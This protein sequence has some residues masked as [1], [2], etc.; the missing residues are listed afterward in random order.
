MTYPEDML[1]HLEV[2]KCLPEPWVAARP[3]SFSL[4]P[5]FATF[6]TDWGYVLME[7]GPLQFVYQ[8]VQYKYM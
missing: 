8:G 1:F 5:Y 2:T 7:N 6:L 4:D 3:S